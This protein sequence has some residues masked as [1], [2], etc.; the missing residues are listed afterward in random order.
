M[1]LP[2]TNGQIPL[3]SGFAFLQKNEQRIKWQVGKNADLVKH[4]KYIHTKTHIYCLAIGYLTFTTGY[5]INFYTIL[6]LKNMNTWNLSKPWSLV[7]LTIKNWPMDVPPVRWSNKVD[8]WSRHVTSWRKTDLLQASSM[9]LEHGSSNGGYSNISPN[10]YHLSSVISVNDQRSLDLNGRI[11][12][13]TLDDYQFFLFAGHWFSCPLDVHFPY[14]H[15]HC[16]WWNKQ[17]KQQPV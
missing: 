2:V 11:F 15:H 12:F 6:L 10:T 8:L 16:S 14:V 9:D 5:S 7:A 1:D 17:G 4:R 3:S 13:M